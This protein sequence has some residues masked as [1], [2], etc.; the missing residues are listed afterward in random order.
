MRQAGETMM[1]N[2]LV[3][4]IIVSIQNDAASHHGAGDR[5][6]AAIGVN[7]GKP[8]YEIQQALG[9]PITAVRSVFINIEVARHA[10][11]RRLVVLPKQSRA[12]FGSPRFPGT[13]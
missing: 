13:E 1:E 7:F 2:R 4:E 9:L 12:S 8:R 6:M 10:T 5:A 3:L 11:I